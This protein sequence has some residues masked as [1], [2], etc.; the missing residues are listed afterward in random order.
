MKLRNHLLVLILSLTSLARAEEIEL[1]SEQRFQATILKVSEDEVLVLRQIDKEGIR[2]TKEGHFASPSD[3]RTMAIPASQIK[4]IGNVS[5]SSFF[6]V[7]SYNVAYRFASTLDALL[8]AMSGKPF[9]TQLKVWV[10]FIALTTFGIAGVLFALGYVVPGSR[11]TYLG[12]L[13]FVLL[14]GTFLLAVAKI[15]QVLL[16]S[17]PAFGKSGFQILAS[18]LTIV[19]FGVLAQVLSRFT[20][21]HG[22][23]A[24]IVSYF[25]FQ[26]ISIML[27]RFFNLWSV[28]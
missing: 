23:M 5:P 3:L 6:A 2:S 21:L 8:V 28:A 18:L 24:M 13:V 11:L 20:F 4:R 10:V 19:S 27:A 16:S 12:A 17:W 1:E 15:S 7:F 9:L 25:G 22:I 26:W 14:S